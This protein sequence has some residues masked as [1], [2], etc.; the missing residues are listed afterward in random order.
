ML[1]TTLVTGAAG[2]LGTELVKVLASRGHRVIGLVGSPHHAARVLKAGGTPV[3]GDICTAGPW[4]DAVAADWVFQLSLRASCA[5]R[6]DRRADVRASEARVA[7]DRHLFD[8]LASSRTSRVIYVA[9]TSCYGATTAF[10][11]I[12]EDAPRS[13]SAWGRRLQPAL[14]RLEGHALAGHRIVTAFPGWVYGNGGWFAKWVIEPILAGRRVWMFG[15]RSPWISPIHVEDCVRALIHVAE[16]GENGGRYFLVNR[17]A[18]QLYELAD[19]FAAAAGR[20]LR[21]L[22]LP[23]AAAPLL[24]GR[25][26]ASHLAASAVFSN[27]RLRALGYHFVHPTIAQGMRQIVRQHHG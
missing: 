14:D 11:A 13:P 9:D 23:A 12:T 8:A 16:H 1:E 22:R 7:A 18:V 4:Q 6:A 3:L 17:D 5:T 21:A 27:I 20:R 19:A 26:L 25:A 10:R 15:R 24:L 2:F